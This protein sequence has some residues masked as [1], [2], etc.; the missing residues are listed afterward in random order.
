[1]TDVPVVAIIVNECNIPFRS[2]SAC[3]EFFRAQGGDID[4]TRVQRGIDVGVITRIWNKYRQR[5]MEVLFDYL[6]QTE[7]EEG[8]DPNDPQIEM[9]F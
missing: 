1:M 5:T 4:R 7:N 3:A 6:L 8:K 9:E 2:A